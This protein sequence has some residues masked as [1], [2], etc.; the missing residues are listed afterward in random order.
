MHINILNNKQM[1]Y[2]RPCDYGV[3]IWCTGVRIKY[4]VN[5]AG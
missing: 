5:E 1:K 2:V 3:L 4:D